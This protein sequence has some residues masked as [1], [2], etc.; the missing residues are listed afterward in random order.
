MSQLYLN[1]PPCNGKVVLNT[2]CGDIDVELWSKEAP[3]ACRN[4]IQLCMEVPPAPPPLGYG[5]S[6]SMGHP[7]IFPAVLEAVF[8]QRER[9][10][11]DVQP[12]RIPL[13]CV[14]PSP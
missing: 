14:H 2:T 5:G 13:V 9:V 7:P 10:R 3:M 8:A 4:F 11:R 12:C 6:M 1:L